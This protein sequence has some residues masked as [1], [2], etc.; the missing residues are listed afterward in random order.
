MANVTASITGYKNDEEIQDNYVT[1]AAN[2]QWQN[3]WGD[4]ADSESEK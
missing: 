2:N 3:D 4:E 1:G